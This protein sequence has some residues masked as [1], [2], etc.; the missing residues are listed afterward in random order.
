[1]EFFLVLPHIAAAELFLFMRA[2]LDSLILVN[3]YS[4]LHLN[5]LFRDTLLIHVLVIQSEVLVK[6]REMDRE[7]AL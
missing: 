3:Q 2:I 4:L 5:S 7:R 6:D 1:M